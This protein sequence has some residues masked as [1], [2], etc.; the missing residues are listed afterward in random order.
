MRKI[1]DKQLRRSHKKFT[2]KW[3]DVTCLRILFQFQ[4]HFSSIWEACVDVVRMSLN[5]FSEICWNFSNVFFCCYQFMTNEKNCEFYFF[6]K[7][8]WWWR[9]ISGWDAII[10][11]IK[12]QTYRWSLIGE[13][14]CDLCKRDTERQRVFIS[15]QRQG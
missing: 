3:S 1:N 6:G 2:Q 11:F 4:Q 12:Y 8:M 7:T 5:I 9:R 15:W 13:R 10:I 14:I